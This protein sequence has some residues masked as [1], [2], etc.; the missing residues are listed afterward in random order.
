MDKSNDTELIKSLG[1][2]TTVAKL[3]GYDLKKGGAQRVQNWFTRGIPPKVKVERP[4]LFMRF[5]KD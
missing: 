4:D 5:L 1:G 2:A 3:L